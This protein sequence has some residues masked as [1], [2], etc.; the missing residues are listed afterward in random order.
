MAY[1]NATRAFASF[2]SFQELELTFVVSLSL[3]LSSLKILAGIARDSLHKRR[4]TGGR[5]KKWRKKRKYESGR[6]P[7]GTKINS[8]TCVRRVRVRGGNYKFRALRLDSGNFSWPT[9]AVKPTPNT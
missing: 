8:N 4:S 3:S 2:S 7:A 9:E 6:I 1:E 5:Q